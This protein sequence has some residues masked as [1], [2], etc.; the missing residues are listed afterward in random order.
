MLDPTKM[1]AEDEQKAHAVGE[2]NKVH[3]AMYRGFGKWS[4][5]F[6]LDEKNK[7][8]DFL[9]DVTMTSLKFVSPAEMAPES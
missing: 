5:T 4:F 6:Q 3:G 9:N 2:E 1:T 7:I 8:V